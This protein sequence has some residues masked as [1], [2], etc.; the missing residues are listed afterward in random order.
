VLGSAFAVLASACICGLTFPVVAALLPGV[1]ISPPESDQYALGV[2]G[3]FA[4]VSLLVQL[5]AFATHVTLRLRRSNRHTFGQPTAP[6]ASEGT[7]VR[8]SCSCRA[9]AFW[10]GNGNAPHHMDI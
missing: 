3:L 6:I 4:L 9:P 8:V 2:A 10:S 7:E 1:E 5:W